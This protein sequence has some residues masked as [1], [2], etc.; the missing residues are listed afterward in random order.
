MNT[1][2]R[3]PL[4]ALLAVV[5]AAPLA[6]A[7]VIK[8][9]KN[10]PLDTIQ[11][12][13]DAA[14][15]GD[16][17]AVSGGTYF[18]QI[19]ISGDREGLKLLAKGQV[20]VDVG[21][22]PSASFVITVNAPG[23]TVRGFTLRHAPS[24]GFGGGTAISIADPDVRIERCHVEHTFQYGIRAVFGTDRIVVDRCTIDGADV[25]VR[26]E[27]ER[28]VVTRCVLTRIQDDALQVTGDD[29]LVSRNEVWGAL[30]R[31]IVIT[32][33]RGRVE[34]NVVAGSGAGFDGRGDD[35]VIE[36]NHFERLAGDA[37]EHESD[38]AAGTVIANRIR[39]ATGGIT[40]LGDGWRVEKNRLELTAA[41]DVEGTD[42]VVTKNR[43]TRCFGGIVVA[44]ESPLI[45]RN[46]LK[47]GRQARDAIEI[48]G[49]TSGQVLS[50]RIQRWGG[51]GIVLEDTA[52]GVTVDR[53]SIKEIGGAGADENHG[54]L[55]DGG[56]GHVVT[57]NRIKTCRVDGIS[58][59]GDEARIEGN[60]I[61]NAFEDG[62]DVEEGEDVVLRGNVVKNCL[63]EG[64]ENEG[65]NVVCEDN[66]STGNRTDFANDG[67]LA[68]FEGNKIGDGSGPD[69]RPEIDA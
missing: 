1:M 66:R 56:G 3:K 6:R 24:G 7:D 20:V 8:V 69:T 44:G 63:A 48:S 29:A 33:D 10:G 25:G 26:I 57:K 15:P 13:V 39:D 14:G 47:D 59:L 30:G 49:C 16:T 62:I 5:L 19:S 12:G 46:V 55:I 60:T 27:G 43:F 34:R 42:A 18:E 4:V 45:E 64:I 17:V 9:S 31:G 21:E 65:E 32:S 51:A 37:I 58:V 54:I 41:L 2:L 38:D 52:S 40:L 67:S 36:R 61:V 28:P 50:N 68:S 53:N 23:V 35:I 11:A 22:L